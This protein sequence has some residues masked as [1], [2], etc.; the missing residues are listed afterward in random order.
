M[1]LL[2]GE[3]VEP[4]EIDP[5]KHRFIGMF[6]K[7]NP[8]K[9]EGRYILCPCGELLKYMGEERTHYSFGHFD[10]P[11]YQTLKEE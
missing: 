7:P 11:Q 4:S 2:D 9:P 5:T 1:P 6:R 3:F 8:P 10:I